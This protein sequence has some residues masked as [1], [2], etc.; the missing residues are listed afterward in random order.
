M[1]RSEQTID[2]ELTEIL[3]L[4]IGDGG[5]RKQHRGSICANSRAFAAAV[6]ACRSAQSAEVDWLA[7]VPD[8]GGLRD[9]VIL[10]RS[11]SSSGH[12]SRGRLWNRQNC[13]FRPA[14]RCP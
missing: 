4:G 9:D 13:W 11:V 10:A 12:N 1:I 8:K 2:I 14:Y 3:P 6:R 5:L 7:A